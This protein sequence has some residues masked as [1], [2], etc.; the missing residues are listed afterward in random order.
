MRSIQ[1]RP[2]TASP[3]AITACTTFVGTPNIV[4]RS[5][6]DW[7][8][9]QPDGSFVGDRTFFFSVIRPG[10]GATP[11]AISNRILPYLDR[12]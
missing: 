12:E 6:D 1:T 2:T 11:E 3:T 4:A 9:W 10:H 7:S 8:G 5:A